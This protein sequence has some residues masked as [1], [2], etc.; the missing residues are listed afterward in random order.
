MSN[1]YLDEAPQQ[2][3][4]VKFARVEQPSKIFFYQRKDEDGDTIT[5]SPIFAC[6][7]Q[8]AGMFGKFHKLVGVGDGRAYYESLKT[9]KVKEICGTCGGAKFIEQMVEEEGKMVKKQ[10]PCDTCKGFGTVEKTLRSGMVIPVAEAKRVLQEAFDA[11]LEAARG[12]KDRPVYRNVSFDDT[13]MRH[14]NGKNIMD[15][16]NPPD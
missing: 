15:S 3:D 1:Q 4:F 6:K 8:E 13:I 5:D 7:E 10:H 11:E 9:A 16:F 14:K 12:K 2:L